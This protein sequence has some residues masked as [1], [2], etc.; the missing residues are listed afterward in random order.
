MI[1]LVLIAAVAA[2][3]LLSGCA[4]RTA[5]V[6]VHSAPASQSTFARQ[7]RNARI[8]GEGDPAVRILRQRLAVAPESTDLRLELAS[9]YENS[10]YPDL[11]LEHVRIARAYA[12]EELSLASEEARLLIKLDLA[13]E[14]VRVLRTVT[15]AAA[16]PAATHA[17]LAIALDET[18]ELSAGEQAH[19]AALALSPQDDTLLNNLGYN[20]FQQGRAAEAAQVLESAVGRNRENTLARANLARALA[21]GSGAADSAGAVAHWSVAVDPASAHNNLAAA[22]IEQGSYEKARRE[23]DAALAIERQHLA[24][25]NNLKLVSDLDGL[26]ATTQ[27]SPFDG[28]LAA[29]CCLLEKCPR[30]TGAVLKTN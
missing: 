11:A 1:R 14:A 5:A 7:V 8:A 3:C 10:G 18:G 16:A 29:P 13:A 27:A 21:S 9:Q 26:P 20:L 12:P 24:A 22:L 28:T 15:A 17:W 30:R 19:R 25:W 4:Q 6:P 23:L 2:I